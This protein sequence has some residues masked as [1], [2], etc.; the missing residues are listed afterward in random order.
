MIM[1]FRS[2]TFFFI[3]ISFP[4]YAADNVME[5][6]IKQ[7]QLLEEEIKLSRKPDI[8][9]VFN[10]L[11]MK[12]YIK[13]RGI[14]LKEF[15]IQD[16]SRWGKPF[17]VNVFKVKRKSTFIKP[18]RETIKPGDEKKKDNFE[19]EALEL[20]DMPTRYTIVFEGGATL[21]I[22]PSS[23]GFISTTGN[24][25]YSSYKLLTRPLLMVWNT[26]K[27]KSYK[28]FNIVLNEN[29]ARAVYWSI[30]EKSAVILCL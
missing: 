14:N 15:S 6:Y 16:F 4:A 8:Y 29:D 19:L 10:M 2:L 5:N 17:S 3:L 30:P 13:A 21:F 27:G 25:F 20:K 11:E 1:L 26:L 18:A 24:F 22:R 23:E 7:N 12:I 28:A 9:Y